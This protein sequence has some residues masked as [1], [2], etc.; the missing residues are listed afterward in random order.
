MRNTLADFLLEIT[1][2]LL[3]MAASA[4]FLDFVWRVTSGPLR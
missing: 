4:W 1:A 2:V 3:L